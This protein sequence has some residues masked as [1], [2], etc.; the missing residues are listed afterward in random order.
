M[1]VFKHSNY[2]VSVAIE[3]L[4]DICLLIAALRYALD[5]SLLAAFCEILA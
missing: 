3:T 5:R 4:I 2:Y 1:Q